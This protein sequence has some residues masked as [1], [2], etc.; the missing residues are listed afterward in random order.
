MGVS[1]S[2]LTIFND[3]V[4]ANYASRLDAPW[5]Q[6]LMSAADGSI[7]VVITGGV[8]RIGD[9]ALAFPS[10]GSISI[11]GTVK[12]IGT[13]ALGMN[14]CSSIVIPASVTSLGEAVFG[15]N[16]DQ[17]IVFEGKLPTIATGGQW[18][19]LFDRCNNLTVSYSNSSWSRVAGQD[20]GGT[21]IVWL[22]D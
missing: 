21:N 12:S 14:S 10:V 5:A 3:S 17:H 13:M 20:F 19:E 22:A 8:T 6:D 16:H 11:P 1:G 9:R 15:L 4:M 2:T 7:R 18:V